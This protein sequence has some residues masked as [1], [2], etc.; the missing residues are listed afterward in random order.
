MFLFFENNFIK[1]FKKLR[2]L[3]TKINKEQKF[4]R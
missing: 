2:I 4:E 1:R 3:N